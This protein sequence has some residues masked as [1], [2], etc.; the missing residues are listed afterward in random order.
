MQRPAYPYA[1]D[2]DIDH[3]MREICVEELPRLVFEKV[4]DYSTA[5]GSEVWSS[6]REAKSECIQALVE[7]SK[8]IR[9]GYI[10]AFE[11]D[12]AREILEVLRNEDEINRI[13]Q[14]WDESKIA[15]L[16]TALVCW[17][18]FFS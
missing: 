14:H 9:G 15:M 6:L 13:I 18:P 1:S 12:L 8:A 3:S 10:T 5:I 2:Q 11:Q 7:L 4:S 17:K 16:L